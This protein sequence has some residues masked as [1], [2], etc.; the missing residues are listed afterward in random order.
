[1]ANKSTP[2]ELATKKKSTP[3]TSKTSSTKSKTTSSKTTKK[4]TKEVTK[5]VKKNN[6]AAILGLACLIAGALGG[7]VG[8]KIFTKNDTFE[9]NEYVYENQMKNVNNETAKDLYPDLGNETA[10]LFVNEAYKE[11]GTTCISFNQD[12]TSEVVTTYYYREDIS[13][14]YTKVNSVDTSISG[15]YYAVY[16]VENFKYSGVD[17]IR[18]II[19][20]EVELDG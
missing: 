4:V 13:H 2:K 18:N 6:T 9:M 5:I 12:I 11:A 7:F 17:L 20:L 14:D 10:V 15:Y 1:M 3:S 16:N 8:Y 19:V